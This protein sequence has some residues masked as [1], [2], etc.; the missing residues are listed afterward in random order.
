MKL[1][2]HLIK[3]RHVC[4]SALVER[5]TNAQVLA[6]GAFETYYVNCRAAER[7]HQGDEGLVNE[8]VPIPP[9]RGMLHFS[10]DVDGSGCNKAGD[11]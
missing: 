5:A 6:K 4:L 11:Q 9:V 7:L 3:R 10:Q 1:E 2:L 8:V